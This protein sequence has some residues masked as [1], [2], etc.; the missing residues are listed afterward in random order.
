M[1][2]LRPKPTLD[3]HYSS[4]LW[5]LAIVDQGQQFNCQEVI[6]TQAVD[7]G[8]TL[9]D[10]ILREEPSQALWLRISAFAPR[11]RLAKLM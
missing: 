2:L 5:P 1:T 10:D 3:P 7:L 8:R 11:H 4:G 6:R 9:L